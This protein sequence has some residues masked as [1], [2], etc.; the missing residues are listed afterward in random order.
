MS[1]AP[2]V[3]TDVMLVKVKG[4]AAHEVSLDRAQLEESNSSHSKSSRYRPTVVQIS[5]VIITLTANTAA[6]I[7]IRM[8]HNRTIAT[9]I[10]RGVL[11]VLVETDGTEIRLVCPDRMSQLNWVARL[12]PKHERDIVHAEPQRPVDDE[13]SAM[14]NRAREL[15]AATALQSV[16][17]PANSPMVHGSPGGGPFSR[18]VTEATDIFSAFTI[19][20]MAS[21]PPKQ[22][23]KIAQ[24]PD[25]SNSVMGA[26]LNTWV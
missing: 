19:D 11:Y 24:K 14:Y 25:E 12:Q 5:G 1:A 17:S 21:S 26:E 20:P 18:P 6:P 13:Q 2:S 23:D 9:S 10:K 4:D 3:Y 7:T 22:A 8:V 16:C 15:L